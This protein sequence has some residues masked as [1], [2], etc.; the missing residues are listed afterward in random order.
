[1]RRKRKGSWRSIGASRTSCR[2]RPAITRLGDARLEGL[3]GATLGSS[4]RNGKPLPTPQ[5][6]LELTDRIASVPLPGEADPDEAG[7]TLRRQCELIRAIAPETA[8]RVS[9]L[10]E[11]LAP[12]DPQPI[13]SI[14]G[15]FHEGQILVENGRIEGLL[16]IDDAG[17]GQRVDD[18]ALWRA[19]SG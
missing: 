10:E 6:L 16:D 7:R 1:M 5:D 11:A 3:P 12:R 2:S 17:P 19:V 4:L 13:E 9:L 15:D 14:H 8:E 18:V